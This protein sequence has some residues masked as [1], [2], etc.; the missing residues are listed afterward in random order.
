MRRRHGEQNGRLVYMLER[1]AIETRDAAAFGQILTA[2]FDAV[3]AV[4]V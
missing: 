1:G 4:Q 3:C 2:A